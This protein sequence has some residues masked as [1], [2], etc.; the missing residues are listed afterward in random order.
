MF[1]QSQGF[2]RV[3]V[4][5]REV[6]PFV[7]IRELVGFTYMIHVDVVDG[8]VDDSVLSVS[9]IEPEWLIFAGK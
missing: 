7:M 6:I 8:D 1:Y 9:R 3:E 4:F 5:G 2:T